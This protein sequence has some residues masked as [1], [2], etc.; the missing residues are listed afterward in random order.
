MFF[1]ES[2]RKKSRNKIQSQLPQSC[3]GNPRDRNASGKS[4]CIHTAAAYNTEK[5]RQEASRRRPRKKTRQNGEREGRVC[6]LC[7]LS[8]EFIQRIFCF[9]ATGRG[10]NVSRLRPLR[11]IC[12]PLYIYCTRVHE[13]VYTCVQY[14]CARARIYS[15][16]A[17]SYS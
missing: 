7:D 14:A 12:T 15:S 6:V 17:Y 1:R 13:C 16:L 2:S 5:A 3:F 11:S 9:R 4:W 8:L 10:P